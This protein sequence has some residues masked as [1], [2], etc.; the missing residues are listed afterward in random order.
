M[1]KR[2]L[3][4][5]DDRE[6]SEAIVPVLGALARDSGATV[7]LLRVLP[8]P[9][10]LVG[11]DGRIVAYVDQETSRLTAHGTED[12]R[13]I[14]AQLDGVAVESVVRFGEPV[15]EILLEAEAFDADLIA[16]ASPDG[17]RLRRAIAPGV[18]DRVAAR[19]PVPTLLLRG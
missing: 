1:A 14:E 18:A 6:P 12:L 4:P 13:R 5:F 16:L 9:E 17:G 8:V 15:A 3:A 10:L 19:A 2:I 7:R 11:T